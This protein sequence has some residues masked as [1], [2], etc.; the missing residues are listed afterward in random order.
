M[1]N[2]ALWP[3]NEVHLYENT[4]PAGQW[5]LL[6]LEGDGVTANRSAIGARVTVKSGGH[7]VTR[8]VSGGYG[9]FGMQHDTALS[10]GLGATCEP[11]A[12]EVRWPNGALTRARYTGIGG[13]RRI[14]IKESGEVTEVAK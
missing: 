1:S 2:A 3:A 9:H 10:F 12:I 14:L 13:G 7:T 6:H 4:A 5:L 8:E 11:T